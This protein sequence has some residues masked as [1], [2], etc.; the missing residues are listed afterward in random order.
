[1][2]KLFLMLSF[3]L[4][5][6]Q[7]CTYNMSSSVSSAYL[8]DQ[9]E[10]SKNYELVIGKARQYYPFPFYGLFPIGKDSVETAIEDALVGVPGHTL[11]NVFMDKNITFIPSPVLP[12]IYYTETSVVGTPVKIKGRE[13]RYE[14]IQSK[15]ENQLKTDEI[16]F[17]YRVLLALDLKKR[18]SYWK[19]Q[20]VQDRERI[21][22]H[23]LSKGTLESEK[24][25]AGGIWNTFTITT[26][27]S[28]TERILVKWIIKKRLIRVRFE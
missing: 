2:S 25:N 11:V 20:D 22:Q 12:L 6:L 13:V 7:G 23:A 26:R 21:Y 19:K 1:M 5:S 10:I 28:E 8:G 17:E 27:F 9:M 16:P 18:D 24:G 14:I 3:I 15:K 4:L